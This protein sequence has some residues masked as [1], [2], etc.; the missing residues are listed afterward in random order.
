MFQDT[1]YKILSQ[2]VH[3]QCLL[4]LCFIGG[5]FFNSLCIRIT[6]MPECIWSVL[7]LKRVKIPESRCC[8]DKTPTE[9]IF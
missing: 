1:S 4:E 9:R 7:L 6:V 2:R 8:G 3:D 5:T